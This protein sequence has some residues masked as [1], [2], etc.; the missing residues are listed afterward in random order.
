MSKFKEGSLIIEI[1]SKCDLNEEFDFN[2]TQ[3]DL[4]NY[5]RL[6]LNK[7]KDSKASKEIF[8]DL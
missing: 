3:Q 8:V 2:E 1:D 5:N 6:N 4:K 7:R